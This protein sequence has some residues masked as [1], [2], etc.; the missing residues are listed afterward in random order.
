MRTTRSTRATVTAIAL[1]LAACG[2]PEDS[3]SVDPPG[4]VAPS[5]PTTV[6]TD[7]PARSD[8]TPTSVPAT[9]TTPSSTTTAAATTT[10][11]SAW[12]DDVAAF[13]SAVFNGIAA[14]A[15]HDGSATDI[16]RYITDVQS[17]VGDVPR[18]DAI[19]GPPDVQPAL[20][21]IAVIWQDAS[22][23]LSRA[24]ELV[25]AGDAGA[26]S[27]ALGRAADDANRVRG[28]LALT[29]ATCDTADPGRAHAGA[30]NVPTEGNTFMINAGFGSIWASQTRAGRVTRH[31]PATGAIVAT[32][33]VGPGAVKLQAADGRMWV[34]TADRYVAIDPATDTIAATLDKAAVGPS[35]NRSFAIDGALWICDGR[36]LHR[37]DP[38][39]LQPVAV[40]DLATECEEVYATSDLV[41]AYRTN[42]DPAQSGAAAAT[43]VD[44]ASNQSVA[45]V[46]LP[47]DV[48]Y[49][50]VLDDEV[51]FPGQD[52]STAVV[53]DRSTWT[54][55]A[56]PDL[57]RPTR[58]GLTATDGAR[59]YAPLAG[60]RDV[61]VVDGDT[62]EVVDTIDTLGNAAPV[63]LDESLW[64]ADSWYGLMQRH[65]LD[66][67]SEATQH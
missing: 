30:L 61:V 37:Y 2:S 23:S 44:P 58:V 31:D 32:I 46:S 62:F 5:S 33:D 64:T 65:D 59:I 10:A 66:E 53:I 27:D 24:A 49:P 21:E 25:G 1:A 9:T 36:R 63:L 14:V 40:V 50:A 56:T 13:C 55:V 17:G 15:P 67:T 35:A 20:D 60:Y 42:E 29:G 3:G 41:V 8:P 19:E 45:T 34:R 39:T 6:V 43:F 52:S 54:V 22:A 47:V 16:S 57:G 38:T 18:L 4:N 48:A 11:P 7:R 26:A 28:R 12:R 51:F